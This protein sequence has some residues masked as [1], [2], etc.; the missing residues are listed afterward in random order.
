M[1]NINLVIWVFFCR[2]ASNMFITELPTLAFNDVTFS[3][4]VD[5]SGNLINSIAEKAFF[6]S[7]ADVL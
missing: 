6:V 3:D 2:S 4:D 7:V 1:G 5:L